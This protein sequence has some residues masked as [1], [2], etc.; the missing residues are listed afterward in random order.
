MCTSCLALGPGNGLQQLC[1]R[2]HTHHGRMA[3]ASRLICDRHRGTA[4]NNAC[5]AMHALYMNFIQCMLHRCECWCNSITEYSYERMGQP[6]QCHLQHV[7]TAQHAAAQ[8]SAC[9]HAAHAQVRLFESSIYAA[10]VVLQSDTDVCCLPL[11]QVQHNRH[12]T[13]HT[14]RLIPEIQCLW[15]SRAIR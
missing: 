5:K 12:A 11:L 3:C 2:L 8:L 10:A 15:L 6:K 4:P 1:A 14:H 7:A 9:T 13:R